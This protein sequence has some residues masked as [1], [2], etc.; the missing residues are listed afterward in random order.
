MLSH[1]SHFHLETIALW[2]Q[3]K[4]KVS[5]SGY[6]HEESGIYKVQRKGAKMNYLHTTEFD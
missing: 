4:K 1:R 2:D 6:F 3:T 5:A